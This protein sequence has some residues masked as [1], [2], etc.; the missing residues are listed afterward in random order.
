MRFA[1]EE[2]KKLPKFSPGETER[3]Y[4]MLS[5]SNWTRV[6]SC[7]EASHDWLG[8]RNLTAIL[9]V[10]VSI[11]ISSGSDGKSAFLVLHMISTDDG[12]MITC[13]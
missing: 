8:S 9:Y 10:K 5:N 4:R 3:V 7:F 6:M 1:L 13:R 2:G 11:A 12:F